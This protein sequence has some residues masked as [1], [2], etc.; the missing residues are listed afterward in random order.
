MT[1]Y[2]LKPTF[3]KLLRPLA[4]SLVTHG[5]TANGV[6]MAALALS[7]IQAAA[8]V[9]T[10]GAS[11]TLLLMPLTLFT[12]MALNAID[13]IMAKE[14][15][16]QSRLGAYLNE[17]GDVISD[18]ALILSMAWV[19]GMAL[20]PVVLFAFGAV[21]SEYVGVLGWAVTGSRRY[22]GPFGKSDRA[23]FIG[24]LALLYGVGWI[25]EK[26][27]TFSVVLAALLT[28][29]TIYNRIKGGLQ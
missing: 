10:C 22:D 8:V 6:T 26:F 14:F 5:A 11:W 29:P 2:D 3:Q 12:R 9:L 21:V 27:G 4:A 13:G 18:A 17:L 7:L 19:P 28:L 15:G 24:I 23:A 1:I 25:S 20:W 16:Q